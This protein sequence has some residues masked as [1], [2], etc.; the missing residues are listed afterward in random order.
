MRRTLSLMVFVLLTF[1]W[2][3]SGCGRANPEQETNPLMEAGFPAYT[4]VPTWT[5]TPLA[6]APS[7]ATPATVRGAQIAAQSIAAQ[8]SRPAQPTEETV[9]PTT[10][11]LRATDTPTPTT[12]SVPV[13]SASLPRSIVEADRVF[14]EQ[15]VALYNEMMAVYPSNEDLD[16]WANAELFSDYADAFDAI[17]IPD[18]DYASLMRSSLALMASDI[19]LFHSSYY[20]GD[21]AASRFYQEDAL[22]SYRNFLEYRYRYLTELGLSEEEAGFEE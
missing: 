7:T 1:V 16:M 17:P 11:V 15:F 6:S 2:A 20:V 22:V 10:Q 9:I 14:L 18:N 4:P 19:G 21:Y 12:E 3:L 8:D 5:P 13:V